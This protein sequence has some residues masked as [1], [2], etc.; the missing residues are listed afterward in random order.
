[1]AADAADEYVVPA[2]IFG[3]QTVVRRPLW[4]GGVEYNTIRAPS[5]NLVPSSNLFLLFLR[6]D[7]SRCIY[8]IAA[9]FVL[10]WTS[11][12]RLCLRA[13]LTGLKHLCPNIFHLVNSSVACLTIVKLVIVAIYEMKFLYVYLFN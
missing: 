9:G 5:S 1:M 12:D 4:R 8:S 3:F 6:S 11:I 13:N 10:A 2:A 7:L